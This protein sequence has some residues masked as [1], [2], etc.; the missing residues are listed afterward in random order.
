M[1]SVNTPAC[2]LVIVVAIKLDALVKGVA[3][4][5]WSSLESSLAFGNG[6]QS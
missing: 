5:A 3:K 6:D 4:W 1:L 2:L